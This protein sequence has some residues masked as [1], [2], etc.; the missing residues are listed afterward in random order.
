MPCG[1]VRLTRVAIRELIGRLGAMKEGQLTPP[2]NLYLGYRLMTDPGAAILARGSS[3]K[4][5][6][7]KHQQF[8]GRSAF[9]KCGE[10]CR[11]RCSSSMSVMRISP[12]RSGTYV[13]STTEG[14]NLTSIYFEPVRVS[15]MEANSMV[16]PPL[17]RGDRS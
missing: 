11:P 3:A 8:L 13:C 4:G 7:I 17:E 14:L 16:L 2:N 15:D 6:E 10:R 9:T 12:S 1:T 5:Y